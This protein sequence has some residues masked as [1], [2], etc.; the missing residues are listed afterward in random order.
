VSEDGRPVEGPEESIATLQRELEDLR[1][2]VLA[3]IARRPV[4]DVELAFRAT[5]KAGTLFMQGQTLQRA[6]Y[7]ALW[8]W[9]QAS[10][11]VVTGGYGAG[12]GSTTFTLPD[13]RG[14]VPVGAGTLGG[15]TYALGA[16]TGAARVTLT[17]AQMPAHDHGSVANHSHAAADNHEHYFQ[18]STTG[19]HG[20]HVGSQVGRT[21]GSDFA[22][23]PSTTS[24]GSHWHDGYTAFSGGHSHPAAGGHT[25]TSQGSGSAVDARPPALAINIAVWTGRTD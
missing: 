4:G 18:T 12:N 2:T 21:T 14:R 23:H 25:H 11:A 15:D 8:E 6:D 24:G 1:S 3:R 13:F 17:L 9:A 20:G 16:L 19:S 5:P 7:P 10:G 22:A